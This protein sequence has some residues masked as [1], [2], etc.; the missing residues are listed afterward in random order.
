M[1]D[2][3]S[4]DV[5]YRSP[6]IWALLDSR[7]RVLT[8]LLAIISFLLPWCLDEIT[9]SYKVLSFYDKLNQFHA[10]SSVTKLI[11]KIVLFKYDSKLSD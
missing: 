5:T 2:H 8:E 6:H 3:R 11:A 1:S 7:F 4:T 10:S 9:Y